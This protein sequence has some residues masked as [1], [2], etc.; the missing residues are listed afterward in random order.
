MGMGEPMMNLDNVLEACA[1][2]PDI[3]ITNRRTAISTIG[4]IPGIERLAEDPMPIR[5]ALSLHAADP[6]LR[7]E[8]M[9]VNDRYPLTE[10]LAACRALLRAQA[11]RG[12]R[13]VRDARRRQRLVRAGGAAR[14]SCSTRACSRST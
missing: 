2:L 12:V 3:G 10:V 5:L 8:L 11:T 4:W 9:P 7:S 6:A 1:R 14:A 13:R